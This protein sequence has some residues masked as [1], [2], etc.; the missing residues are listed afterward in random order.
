MFYNV[1]NAFARTSGG[2]YIVP[3]DWIITI[4]FVLGVFQVIFWFVNTLGID[5]KFD[6]KD[7]TESVIGNTFTPAAL[8][9]SIVVIMALLGFGT[10]I[11][12][13]E[14]LHLPRYANFSVEQT[15]TQNEQALDTAGLNAA[16]IKTFLQ[17]QDATILV[18]RALYP[19]YYKKNQG[20]PL[21]YPTLKL[22]FPRTTFTLIGPDGEHGVILPGD[23]PQH[24]PH[25]ADVIVIGCQGANYLDALA[26]IVLDENRSVYVRAPQSELQ[27]QLQQ[28]VCDNN[29]NCK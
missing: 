13:S 8:S 19:R 27:C 6:P 28:P 20:E 17:S 2:R 21:F 1:S 14:A 10:L 11:P 25:A 24:F 9:K 22:P 29:T 26:I 15:L 5:W 3:M 18:G 16:S 4:Y 12:L 7:E 23:V